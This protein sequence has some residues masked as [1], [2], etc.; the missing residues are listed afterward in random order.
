MG[1]TKPVKAKPVKPKTS[2]A[3]PKQKPKP[4]T[5]GAKPKPKEKPKLKPKSI[6]KETGKVIVQ[7]S[8]AEKKIDETVYCDKLKHLVH[9][10]KNQNLFTD[11]GIRF[12]W[13]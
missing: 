6:P 4:K 3:K 12:A 7:M 2:G 10:I 9:K 11:T 8:P 1:E 5:S 13:K